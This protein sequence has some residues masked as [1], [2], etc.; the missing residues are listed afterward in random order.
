[1]QEQGRRSERTNIPF[2]LADPKL[3]GEFLKGAE[4]RGMV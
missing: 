3:D 2:A 4:G 1:M